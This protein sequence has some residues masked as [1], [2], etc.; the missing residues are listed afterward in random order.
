MLQNSP[1][2]SLVKHGYRKKKLSNTA[3]LTFILLAGSILSACSSLKYTLPDPVAKLENTKTINRSKEEVWDD[4]IPK[5]GKRFFVINNLDKDSGLI[6]VSYS[7]NPGT[8]IDCGKMLIKNP[9]NKFQDSINVSVASESQDYASGGAIFNVRMQLE[10][11][12]NLILQSLEQ[13]K[14]LVSANTRYIVTKTLTYRPSFMT[15][16]NP[17]GPLKISF[18]TGQRSTFSDPVN[19]VTCQSTGK[20][21]SDLLELA[22]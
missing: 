13:Q 21:E 16:P 7:G 22:N 6:N 8:Y 18:N 5:L 12:V 1:N 10:G 20:L 9:D 3:N 17:P 15:L 2:C 4:L 11:R 19:G 14:T